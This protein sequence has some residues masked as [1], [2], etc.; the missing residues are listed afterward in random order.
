MKPADQNMIISPDATLAWTARLQE[1]LVQ[2]LPNQPVSLSS[3]SHQL[4]VS[5]RTLQRR[6]R[7]E[8]TSWREQ[9]DAVRRQQATRLLGEGKTRLSVAVRL[10]YRDD[11]TL[12][13]AMH[14]W[15]QRRAPAVHRPTGTAASDAHTEH[16]GAST[17]HSVVFCP[18]PPGRA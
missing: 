16:R 11:R 10:G 17:T 3:M 5:P 6:L 4:A 7:E 13:R 8:G 1:L 14:R 9:I 2:R 18:P 12:R 15:N